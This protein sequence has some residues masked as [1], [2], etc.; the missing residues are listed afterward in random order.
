MI[1]IRD[2]E[3]EDAARLAHLIAELGYSVER[4]ELWDRLRRCL[5]SFIEL[6]SPSL[7]TE[8]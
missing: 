6:S 5:P 3:R 2:A 7:E 1:S 4:K 8:W